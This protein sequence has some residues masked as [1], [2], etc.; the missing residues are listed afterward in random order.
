MINLIKKIFVYDK[1]F[2][3]VL[4]VFIIMLS[5][6]LFTIESK[7]EQEVIL[8]L[9]WI[10]ATSSLQISTSN[11]FTADYHN[12]LLEQIFIQP[13][14]SKLIVSCKI[15]AHWLLFG[16]SISL[17]SSIFSFVIF[18]NNIRYSI[19]V[20]LS[21]LFNTL[22][23]ISISAVGNALVLGQANLVSGISQILV[24]PIIMPIFI[25]FKLLIQTENLSF[26]IYKLL[27]TTLI[28]FI[29]LMNS[30]IGTHFALKFALEQD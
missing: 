21:L 28:F 8:T 19:A 4:S 7:S 1:N 13:L 27:I 2:I 10:C 9:I 14:S 23:V 24:L 11:L 26:N 22:I 12:G 30:I 17:I 16:L 5:L 25:Y 6:S 15:F 3:Y 18:D 20:G 29:L